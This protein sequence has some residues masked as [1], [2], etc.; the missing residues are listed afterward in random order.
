MRRKC[1]EWF[2]NCG[3]PANRDGGKALPVSL[4]VVKQTVKLTFVSAFVALI[5]SHLLV[6]PKLLLRENLV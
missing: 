4:L 2:D 1:A 3:Q 5:S 6:V